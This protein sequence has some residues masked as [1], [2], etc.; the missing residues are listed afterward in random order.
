MSKRL[1]NKIA[2]EKVRD[3]DERSKDRS[4]RK[5]SEI[6]STATTRYTN[7]PKVEVGELVLCKFVFRC[8]IEKANC[9]RC[10]RY[11]A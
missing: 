2:A 6:V 10:S 3:R 5:K 1:T 9:K 8:V 11:Q 4:V 7:M